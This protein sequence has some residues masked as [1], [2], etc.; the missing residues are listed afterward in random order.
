[1]NDV[2]TKLREFLHTF[3]GG[4]PSTPTGVEIKI[5]KKLFSPEDAA[6]YLSLT[7]EPEERGAIA[8]RLGSFQLVLSGMRTMPTSWKSRG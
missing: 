7:K 3:P 5:L 8:K 4:Y 1:M 6:L 2:Y